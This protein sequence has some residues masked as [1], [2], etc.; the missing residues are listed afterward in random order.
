VSD[1]GVLRFEEKTPYNMLQHASLKLKKAN[2]VTLLNHLALKLKESLSQH[3]E[4]KSLVAQLR[5][6][7][8]KAVSS[9]EQIMQDVAQLKDE[10]RRVQS[11]LQIEE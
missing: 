2:N 9:N 10:N 11:Q 4:S 7:Y 1:E 3:E 5:D 8:G 6:A